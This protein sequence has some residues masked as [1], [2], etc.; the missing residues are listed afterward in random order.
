MTTVLDLRTGDELTYS[1][2]P[3]KAVIAAFQQNRKNYSWWVKSY[4][5]VPVLVGQISVSCGNFCSIRRRPRR[6]R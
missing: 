3:V 4:W 1:L 5:D 6:L 2:T